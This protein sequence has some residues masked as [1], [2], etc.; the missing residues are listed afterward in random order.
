MRPRDFKY[1]VRSSL[2]QDARTVLRPNTNS[3]N[4]ER[5]TLA[6]ELYIVFFLLAII[7]QKLLE[8]ET[9][10]GWI[11]LGLVL[12]ANYKPD[13]LKKIYDETFTGML[14]ISVSLIIFDLIIDVQ[15]LGDGDSFST[16]RIQQL[17]EIIFFVGISGIAVT[18]GAFVGNEAREMIKKRF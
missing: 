10:V 18:F 17:I 4:M 3:E 5:K 16:D 8:P 1:S 9:I 6:M 12:G 13:L 15:F 11:S 2:R 7:S 14:L